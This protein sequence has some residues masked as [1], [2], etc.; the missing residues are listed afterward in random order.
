MELL[1]CCGLEE[2]HLTGALGCSQMLGGRGWP[3]NRVVT[4]YSK[5]VSLSQPFEAKVQ[6]ERQLV[7][8]VTRNKHVKRH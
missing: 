7:V 8:D 4:H 5:S 6:I 2:G 1:E 3:S